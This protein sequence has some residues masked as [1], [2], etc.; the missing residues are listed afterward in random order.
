MKYENV[1]KIN[2][3]KSND[4]REIEEMIE[5]LI[6]EIPVDR[7]LVI[8]SNILSMGKVH[9]AMRAGVKTLKEEYQ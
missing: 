8:A 5:S 9:D 4:V 6:N 2:E 7:Q 3:I 1:K